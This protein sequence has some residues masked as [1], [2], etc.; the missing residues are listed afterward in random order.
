MDCLGRYVNGL[1]GLFPDV[2]DGIMKGGS[3]QP[4]DL[5]LF[6]FIVNGLL[7]SLIGLF[8]FIGNLL[9]IIILF[10]LQR[11]ST[12]STNV[13][14]IALAIFDVIVVVLPIFKIGIPAI[15]EYLKD[16]YSCY[17]TDNIA[18]RI[19]FVL[20]GLSNIALTGSAYCTLAVTVERY[21][22]ICW[23]FKSMT[24]CTFGKAK[25]TVIAISAAS[26]IYNIPRFLEHEM[27]MIPDSCTEI[28]YIGCGYLS[29][30]KTYRGAHWWMFI[31]VQYIIPF[32]CLTVLNVLTYFEVKKSTAREASATMSTISRDTRSDRKLAAVVIRLVLVYQICYLPVLMLFIWNA[33][34]FIGNSEWYDAIKSVGN[35]MIDL[36]SSVN[37]L[38]Y[39]INS[40][41]FR[42]ELR[43]FGKI[44][45]SKMCAEN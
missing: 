36:N 25:N 27:S 2:L 11:R 4:F 28:P 39:I 24:I 37:F 12:S 29:K 13:I 3:T 7:M 1:L 9:C 38:I 42:K 45:S 41:K 8:G 31:V 20:Y 15:C 23:P 26:I 18:P 35:A 6:K 19:F 17:Y 21:I 43:I 22:A 32:V 10:R 34:K 33:G 14:L 44:C 40:N 30:S 16:Q 5:T